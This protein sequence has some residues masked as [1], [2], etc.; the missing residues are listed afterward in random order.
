MK[1][2]D[3]PHYLHCVVDISGTK[4]IDREPIIDFL[5]KN[6]SAEEIVP[7]SEFAPT[8]ASG[9]SDKGHPSLKTRPTRL[10]ND[11]CIELF[12]KCV[13]TINPLPN[14][15]TTPVAGRIQKEVRTD[16]DLKGIV[17][18]LLLQQDAIT[19]THV[20]SLADKPKV[21]YIATETPLT[22]RITRN[23]V[24]L[25]KEPIGKKKMDERLAVLS[26]EI[27][28]AVEMSISI[29]E[30]LRVEAKYRR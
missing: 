16:D 24:V 10:N 27:A 14:F 9:M 28:D 21:G 7:P 23:S 26:Q 11:E 22:N 13:Q 2:Y 15:R 29:E 3:R 6:Y 18:A 8:V 17:E 25:S 12:T 20:F 5:K 4:P 19:I 1:Y 30:S